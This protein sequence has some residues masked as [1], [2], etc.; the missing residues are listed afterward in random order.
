VPVQITAAARS[1][2]LGTVRRYLRA[3]PHRAARPD[4]ARK[5]VETYDTAVATIAAGPSI[6]FAYPRPYPSL[7][8]YGFRWI[9]VHRYWVAYVPGPDPI[10]TNILDQ[11]ADIEVHISSE[12]EPFGDA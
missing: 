2:Y 11:A 1:Q 5:L 9:K 8:V 6:S 12:R 4:A 7:D 3:T 10:I